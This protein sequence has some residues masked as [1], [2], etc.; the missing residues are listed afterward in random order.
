MEIAAISPEL[1]EKVIKSLTE[2]IDN[3]EKQQN[4]HQK[5]GN[6][7]RRSKNNKN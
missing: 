4:S 5:I 7:K 6:E 2:I 1:N 3:F